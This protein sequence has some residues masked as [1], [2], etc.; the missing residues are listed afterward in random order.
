MKMDLNYRELKIIEACLAV[1]SLETTFDNDDHAIWQKI[2][3]ALKIAKDE[4]QS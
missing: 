4:E 2:A 1:T 3:D